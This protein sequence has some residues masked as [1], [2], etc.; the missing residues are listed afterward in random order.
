MVHD[1]AVA[2][3]GRKR[4]FDSSRPFSFIPLVFGDLNATNQYRGPYCP[5]GDIPVYEWRPY[6]L[7]SF[8]TPPFPG[9][10]SGHSTF[11]AATARVLEHF[12][13]SKALPG[14][15]IYIQ[16]K[17]GANRIEPHCFINGTNIYGQICTYK[18]CSFDSNYTSDFHF[19]IS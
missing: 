11:S 13:G 2:C 3:W 16:I 15:P 8:W 4:Y 6:Q 19:F 7:E 10:P 1:A 5:Q 17:K 9:Y 18:T 12:T 14:A